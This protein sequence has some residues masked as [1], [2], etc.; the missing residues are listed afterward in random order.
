MKVTFDLPPYTVGD[1][2]TALAAAYDAL[3][4]AGVEPGR[5]DAAIL[6][7]GH[8]NYPPSSCVEAPEHE[9]EHTHCGDHGDRKYFSALAEHCPSCDDTDCDGVGA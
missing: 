5:L 1:E 8:T 2:S 9:C 3:V 7:R 6:A 4:A